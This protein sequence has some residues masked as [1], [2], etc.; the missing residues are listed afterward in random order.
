MKELLSYILETIL[1]KKDFEIEEAE[2][3]GHVTFRVKAK[4]EDIGLIIGKGGNTIKAI[5]TILRIRAR[6]ENKM[7]NLTVE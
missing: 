3:E 2:E 7:V 6:I 5:S 4:Q 1:G